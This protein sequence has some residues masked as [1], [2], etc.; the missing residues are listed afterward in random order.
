MAEHELKFPATKAGD[1]AADVKARQL[2][3]DPNTYDVSHQT[4]SD[5]HVVKYKTRD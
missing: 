5:G 3:N 2:A 1:N 4:R